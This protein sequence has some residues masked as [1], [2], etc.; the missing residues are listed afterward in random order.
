VKDCV[1]ETSAG[2]ITDVLDSGVGA[3]L[4]GA[5]IGDRRSAASAGAL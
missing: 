5:A 2:R 3:A 1:V 4:A